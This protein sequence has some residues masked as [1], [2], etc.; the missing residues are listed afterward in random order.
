[1]IV[2]TLT[3]VPMSLRGDLTKWCQEIQTGVYVGNPNAKIRDLLWERVVKNIGS[4]R[5]TMAYNTNNEIGYMFRSTDKSVSIENFDGIPLIK[6]LST[7]DAQPKHGFSKAYKY[8]QA[9]KYSTFTHKK[10]LSMSKTMT[11]IDIETTGLDVESDV[12][13]SVGAVKNI[14]GNQSEFYRLIKSE[15]EIPEKIARLTG[16]SNQNIDEN[17]QNLNQVLGDLRKFLGDSTI[18]GYNVQFD[19][20]FLNAAFETNG[21]ATIENESLDLLRMVKRK[22]KFLDNYR[23]E[24]VLHKYN[25]ENENP[26]NALSDAKATLQL[27]LKLNKNDA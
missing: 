5:A 16:I 6:H 12:I 11:A 22:D 7:V 27:A 19:L 4:G 24:T 15:A 25:I 20:Q 14:D 13:L 2:L 21:L 26:H 23:L 3:K 1:M 9:K 18:V 17:G 8:H 10:T